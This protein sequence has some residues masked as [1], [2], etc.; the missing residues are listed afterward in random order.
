MIRSRDLVLFIAILLFLGVGIVGTVTER[1]F[2]ATQDDRTLVFSD[3]EDPQLA[4]VAPDTPTIDREANIQR[5]REKISQ[6]TSVI[7]G[8][9]VTEDPALGE[10]SVADSAQ[11]GPR[12]CSSADDALARAQSWPLAGVTVSIFEG[13]RVVFYEERVAHKPPQTGSTS[14]ST[15]VEQAIVRTPLLQLPVNPQKLSEPACAPSQV[16]GVTVEGSLLF[17]SDAR[18]YQSY[19]PDTLIGYARDGFP[20]YASFAVEEDTCGGIDHPTG[21]RYVIEPA[22]MTVLNCFVGTVQPFEQ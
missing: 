7:S 5:L 12:M 3:Q 10:E 16:V 14:S 11:E 2:F 19:A 13:A 18:L 1:V 8:V 20:I 21:Y 9:S 6:D 15:V 17:N 22:S 4:V